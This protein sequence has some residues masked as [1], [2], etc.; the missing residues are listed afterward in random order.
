MNPPEEFLQV[1]Y[2]L[3]SFLQCKSIQSGKYR[4]LIGRSR[5]TELDYI[6]KCPHLHPNGHLKRDGWLLAVMPSCGR[7]LKNPDVI[8]LKDWHPVTGGN[9]YGTDDPNVDNVNPALPDS[10]AIKFRPMSLI[11]RRI[12]L[13]TRYNSVQ[14]HVTSQ[15]KN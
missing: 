12:L 7:G 14:T 13:S 10:P 1:I 2:T 15:L 4:N 9:M 3:L 8:E 5:A 6:A 11:W